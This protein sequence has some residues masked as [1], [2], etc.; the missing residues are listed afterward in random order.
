MTVSQREY[1]TSQLNHNEDCS[2]ASEDACQH[3]MRSIIW[4]SLPSFTDFCVCE[5]ILVKRISY[6]ENIWTL[7]LNSNVNFFQCRLTENNDVVTQSVEQQSVTFWLTGRE[8]DSYW[9]ERTTLRSMRLKVRTFFSLFGKTLD[10]ADSR[11]GLPLFSCLISLL[12]SIKICNGYR[13]RH[14]FSKI[15]YFQKF[16][17]WIAFL[18]FS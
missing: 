14:F 16:S 5:K 12:I 10:E 7:H 11:L 15:A 9:S 18:A 17:T 1:D 6:R 3:F 8:S 4:H 2:N 13:R